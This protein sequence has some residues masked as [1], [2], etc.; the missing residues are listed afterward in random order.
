MVE[1]VIGQ[2]L[3]VSCTSA[4]SDRSAWRTRSPA[5]RPFAEAARG[6]H[7]GVAAARLSAQGEV[8]DGNAYALGGVAGHAGLFSTASDLSIFAQMILEGGEH[9]GVRIVSDSTVELFTTRAAG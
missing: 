7:R 1:R 8:H 5:V 4:C 3:D 2:G 6:A 9:G